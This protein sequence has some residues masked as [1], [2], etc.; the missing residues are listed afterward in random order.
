MLDPVTLAAL[1]PLLAKAS[2]KI[3]GGL[4]QKAAERHVETF[5]GK[6]LE[7]L[8][9]LGKKDPTIE[10]AQKAYALWF[11]WI[12]QNVKSR[13][14]LATRPAGG[15]DARRDPR[16]AEGAGRRPDRGQ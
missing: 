4:L 15:R 10:A 9:N 16:C 14:G 11:E 13:G 7:W 12:L 8:A 6:K 5:F 2:G 3:A 1:A